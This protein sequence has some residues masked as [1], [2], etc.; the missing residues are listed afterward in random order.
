LELLPQITKDILAKASTL[1]GSAS[2][3]SWDAAV[4]LTAAHKTVVD[5][6]AASV[7]RNFLD[8]LFLPS[9]S[10]SKISPTFR[11]RG[12]EVSQTVRG[13]FGSAASG[14]A[15][16]YRGV[17]G[18]AAEIGR[19]IGSDVATIS[20]AVGAAGRNLGRVTTNWRIGVGEAAS[21][22][23]QR[24]LTGAMSFGNGLNADIARLAKASARGAVGSVEGV[25]SGG[26]KLWH[27]TVES[28]R[29]GG[30]SLRV[31]GGKLWGK[32]VQSMYKL[33]TNSTASGW[34]ALSGMFRGNTSL[35][36]NQQRWVR[37]VLAGAFM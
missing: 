33:K 9:A 13:I 3:R 34:C 28:L 25:K 22:A 14:I 10:W 26:V 31:G 7:R 4:R 15:F 35:V 30:E 27:R 6:A 1:V 17:A 8:R 29:S 37:R 32:T 18:A 5:V 12:S 19:G 16:G 23:W 21:G 20:G 2:Q 24:G 36:N 11:N